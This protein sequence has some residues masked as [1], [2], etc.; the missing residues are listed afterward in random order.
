MLLTHHK[1]ELIELLRPRP[2]G[3]SPRGE[4]NSKFQSFSLD[5]HVIQ[6]SEVQDRKS[7]V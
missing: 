5:E 7:V 1:A 4:S 2:V 3:Q 6:L